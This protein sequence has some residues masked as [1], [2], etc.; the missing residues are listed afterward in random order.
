MKNCRI[1]GLIFFLLT[2]TGLSEAATLYVDSPGART[3]DTIQFILVGE[4]AHFY[5]LA[6][7]NTCAGLVVDGT[8]F[9]LGENANIASAGRLNRNGMANINIIFRG[10]PFACFQAITAPP[11]DYQGYKISNSVIVGNLDSGGPAGPQGPPGEQG[12]QGPQGPPGPPGASGSGFAVRTATFQEGVDG[13]TGCRDT[14]VDMLNPINNYANE[15][16]L[17]VGIVGIVPDAK[18]ILMKFNIQ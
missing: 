18:L 11:W 10:D 4:P 12:P 5:Y 6:W 8:R 7:S 9:N 15:H 1:F 14:W 13:Y 3:G 2:L 17:K 16:E